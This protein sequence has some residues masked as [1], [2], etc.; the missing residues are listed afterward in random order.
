MENKQIQATQQIINLSDSIV[1]YGDGIFETILI[2]VDKGIETY[3]FELHKQRIKFGC[4]KLGIK[5]PDLLKL[6]QKII[7][8]IDL[9]LLDESINYIII[10]VII[11]R[12][13]ALRAYKTSRVQKTKIYIQKTPYKFNAKLYLGAKIR[14]CD[15]KLA[16]QPALAGIKHLN[17]LEQILAKREKDNDLFAEGLILD[18]NNNVIECISSNIF[19]IKNNKII[20]PKLNK[21]GVLGTIRQK[22]FNSKDDII[23]KLNLEVIEEVLRID[24][25]KE[26]DEIFY[27]NAIAGI[28]PITALAIFD[29]KYKIDNIK[30][31]AKIIKHPCAN[32][33]K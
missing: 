11:S 13:E 17:R 21:S 4:L 32:Y 10:K 20:T 12:G 26:A 8:D 2:K 31:L 33:F 24:N 19:I 6:E 7:S 1:Q 22:I 18:A 5:I 14:L 29:K 23:Q 3:N 16:T 25:I 30:E 28:V 15:I 9:N 27:T